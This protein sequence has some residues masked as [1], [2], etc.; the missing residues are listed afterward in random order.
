MRGRRDAFVLDGERHAYLVHPYKRTWTTERAVEVPVIGALVD[1]AGAAAR[2]LEVGHVL[3]HYGARR[4]V[5]VDKYERG[6][7]VLNRDV[8]D[9]ADLGAFDLVV[10]I[11]TVE[12]V[13]W[14]E[15]PRE[16]RK[17]IAAIAALKALLAPGGRL[18]LTVPVGYNPVLDG[19]LRGGEV[20]LTRASALRRDGAGTRWREVPVAEAWDVPYDF[21]LYSARAVV[22]AAIE[23]PAG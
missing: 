9:L 18:H 22:F 4:H 5:V 15:E 10:A 21:L 19:A 1:A 13:G 8:L 6:A 11:S 16:P 14:D 3:G 20:Q 2:V 7:G 17:A 23:R 12:H